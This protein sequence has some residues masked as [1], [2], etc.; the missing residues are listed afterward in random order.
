MDGTACYLPM[1]VTFMA[2]N[3]GLTNKLDAATYILI[4]IMATFGSIGTGE[5]LP[6]NPYSLSLPLNPLNHNP[7]PL[8]LPL[9]PL[10]PNPYTL[11]LPLTPYI[12]I[13][14]PHSFP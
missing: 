14:T 6:L 2:V 5:T 1:T 9:T 4:A 13:L 10:P 11:S 3:A 12:L 7:Y 8:S